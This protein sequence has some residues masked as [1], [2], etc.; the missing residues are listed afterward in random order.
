MPP[1]PVV[2]PAPDPQVVVLRALVDNLDRLG[3]AAAPL[4]LNNPDLCKNHAR[5][6]LGFT[7]KN[8]TS[9][10]TEF[11]QAAQI[12]FQLGERLQV[13]TVLA[14]SGASQVG[15]R[16]G[17]ILISIEGKIIPIGHGAID[18]TSAI[19]AAITARRAN[20]KLVIQ[21]EGVQQEISVPLTRACAQRAELGNSD[22]VNSYADGQRILI[23][24]GMLNFAKTDTEVAY[25]LAKEMAHN[26]L[27]HAA[28]QRSNS[29]TG[30]QIDNLKEIHP[31]LSLLIG[32]AGI[33]PTP[34]ELDIAADTLSVY[35]L[36]R[37]G[38]SIDHLSAFW[39]R[40]ANQYPASVLNAHTALHPGTAARITALEKTVKEVKAK[41]KARQPLT[42]PM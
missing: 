25:L 36:A 42:P 26:I 7:L 30:R 19:F 35:L 24:R 33:K 4:Q 21:R 31:D 22:N 38:Y 23:T 3:Q 5:N 17:D 18:A 37:A 27:G 8:Q 39:Q 32:N 29:I 6:I 41:Q 1:Q 11:I 34:V 40:L 20:V 9:Y 12:L 14:G 2:K 13:D 15:L 10:T 16:R 28:K